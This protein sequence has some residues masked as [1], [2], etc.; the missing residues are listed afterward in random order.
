MKIGDELKVDENENE[1]T[2]FAWTGLDD[3]SYKLVETTTPAGYNTIS[4]IEFT[5]EADHNDTWEAEERTEILIDLTGNKYTG[6]VETGEY[7][8]EVVNKS[9]VELPE[10]GG[11]GTTLF[12]A[13]GAIMVLGAAV[14]LITKKRM[15]IA[16]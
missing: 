15:S 1:L 16:E 13:F 2:T 3:G 7:K 11:M 8:A 4:P 9:G 5:I 6:D 12:Y 14:L 10:T